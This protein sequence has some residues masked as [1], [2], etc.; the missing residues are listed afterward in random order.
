VA[1]SRSVAPPSAVPTITPLPMTG[2]TVSI[3]SRLSNR[4]AGRC[5]AGT[6]SHPATAIAL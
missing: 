1:T 6:E 5:G 2:M 4:V 3:W